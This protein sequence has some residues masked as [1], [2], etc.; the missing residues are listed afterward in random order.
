VPA[1]IPIALLAGVA[2]RMWASGYDAPDGGAPF[3]ITAGPYRHLRYPHL[4]GSLC[5]ALALGAGFTTFRSVF[6]PRLRAA[7]AIEEDRRARF[8]D[9]Y[10]DYAVRVPRFFPRVRP[11][12]LRSAGVFA[13]G[14]A[15]RRE[16]DGIGEIVRLLA[17]PTEGRHER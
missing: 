9:Q 6:G 17:A 2:L 8:G 14:T 11:A 3:L 15:L 13:L 10:R 5:I 4:A 7:A 16:L 1:R 12:E